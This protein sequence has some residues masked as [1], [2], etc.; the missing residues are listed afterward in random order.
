MKID[1]DTL[2]SINVSLHDA[3]GT[4]LEKSDVPLTY[5]HGHG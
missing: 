1:N 3:Q 4:L 5:L 2:V